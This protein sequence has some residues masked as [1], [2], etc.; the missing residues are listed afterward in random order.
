LI[1]PCLDCKK[2][3]LGC[4]SD[5]N[6]YISWVKEKREVLEKKRSY[7]DARLDNFHFRECKRDMKRSFGDTRYN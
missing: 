2:R 3:K 7:Y 5:C 4:H 1:A 6:D